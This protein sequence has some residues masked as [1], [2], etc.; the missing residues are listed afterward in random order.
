MNKWLATLAALCASVV[1]AAANDEQPPALNAGEPLLLPFTEGETQRVTLSLPAGDWLLEASEDFVD[2][3]IDVNPPAGSTQATLHG[4][5]IGVSA[6]SYLITHQQPTTYEL[7]IA[8]QST[9]ARDATLTLSVSAA[10][11]LLANIH[12]ATALRI[13]TTLSQFSRSASDAAYLAT[14]EQAIAAA[15]QWETAGDLRRAGIDLYYAASLLYSLERAAEAHELTLQAA[16]MLATTDD[17]KWQGFARSLAGLTALRL[18]RFDAAQSLLA[19]SEQLLASTYNGRSLNPAKT[20]QCFALMLQNQTAQAERCYRGLI[21]IAEQTGDYASLSTTWR[22]IARTYMARGDFSGAADIL[23][24]ALNELD[25]HADLR[26][27]A[28]LHLRLGLMQDALGYTQQ[29]INNYN[30][31]LDISRQIGDEREVARVLAN[32]GEVYRKLGIPQRAITLLQESVDLRKDGLPEILT[33]TKLKLAGAML[34]ASEFES[35]KTLFEQVQQLATTTRNQSILDIVT[36]G[37]AKI[38]HSQGKHNATIQRLRPLIESMQEDGRSP[39]IL[40]S[41][42]VTCARALL[43]GGNWRES[44]KVAGD[45]SDSFEAQNGHLERAEALSIMAWALWSMERRTEAQALAEQSV[46]LVDGLR[47][48]IASA[49]LRASYQTTIADATEL[50]VHTHLEL[51]DN[52]EQAL[53]VA[54]QFRART[55]I[56]VLSKSSDAQ[57]RQVPAEL[58]RERAQLRARI[59]A[60]ESRRIQGRPSPNISELAFKLDALDGQ[61]AERDPRYRAANNSS[62]LTLAQMQALLGDDDIVIQYYLG[63]RSSYRWLITS[64]TVAWTQLPPA[65]R[66][67]ELARTAHTGLAKRADTRKTAAGL[68]SILFGGLEAQI[69]AS[70]NVIVIADRGLH[71][72]PFDVLRT[73]PDAQPLLAGKPLSYAPSLTTLALNRQTTRRASNAIAVLADPVFNESDQRTQSEVR[74]D[75]TRASDIGKTLNRLPMSALEADAIATLAADYD[76]SMFTGFDANVDAMKTDAVSEASV[77]HI[78]THGFVDDEI[79]ERNGLALSVRTADGRSRPG[80]FGLRD[81]YELRLNAELVVLSACDTALGRD[82]A[83]EGLLGLTR[84]FMLAGASRVLASLWP[85]EDRATAELM[86]HFYEALLIQ[87]QA[88]PAALAYAKQQMQAQRRWRHPYFWSGFVLLGDWAPLQ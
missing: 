61:I 35:A 57:A 76:V 47:N 27:R 86:E 85:V 30:T 45:A 66:L 11:D 39:R 54:E 81:I 14:H 62:A 44:L 51:D 63:D 59:N 84:G 28:S 43:A 7:V 74:A 31:A 42:Q 38:D 19:E 58:E 18:R 3:I 32:L 9:E 33:I 26:L 5:D 37:L 13:D 55:L 29:T 8:A 12:S 78:A 79:P 20:N 68:G 60:A 40:A 24:K 52:P 23:E 73:A 69:K 72:V 34:A 22:N 88:P 6:I 50:L 1:C 10:D 65:A 53:Y 36:L 71:Y 64:E 67:N 70:A 16:Q 75:L 87:K 21:P 80:F 77:L 49:D 15:Q 17:T 25:A 41:V 82:M 2:V 46:T 48:N 4:I 83:G 56:D